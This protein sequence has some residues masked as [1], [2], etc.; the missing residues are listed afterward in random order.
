MEVRHLAQT[1]P[2][3]TDILA[4]EKVGVANGVATLKHP[5]TPWLLVVHETPDAPEAP[6]EHHFG[7]RVEHAE[8][9]DA[10][11]QYINDHKDE[12]GLYGLKEPVFGHGSYSIHFREPG[13]NDWE[14]ECYEAVLRKEAGGQRLGGVRSRHWDTPMESDRFA[15]HGFVPQAFTHGTLHTNDA[16]ACGRFM[17]EVLGLDTHNAYTKVV[18]VKHPDTKHFVVCLENGKP[19]DLDDNFRFT[20]TVESAEAVAEAHELLAQTDG[21]SKLSDVQASGEGASF[22]LRDAD[23]NCWEIAAR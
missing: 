16:P 7:V 11:W 8:E 23:H 3:M 10:A 1:L 17:N 9:V 4:F 14:I 6:S 13:S 22:L 15:S 12:Y 19:N 21:I 5:N 18:Y 20:L 2:V